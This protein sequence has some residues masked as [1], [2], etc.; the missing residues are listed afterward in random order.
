MCDLHWVVMHFPPVS[1]K[2][3]PRKMTSLLNE[4]LGNLLNSRSK[5]WRGV[6]FT[7]FRVEA[8]I[9]RLWLVITLI[10]DFICNVLCAEG[11]K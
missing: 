3:L 7:F 4:A 6:D 11:A 9:A 2:F 1:G 8:S 10:K 5:F